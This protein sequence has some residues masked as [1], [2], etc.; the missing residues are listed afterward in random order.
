MQKVTFVRHGQASYGS[1]N[2]D[3]LSEVGHTQT[4]L[5][6]EHFKQ[7]GYQFDAIYTGKMVRH[8][9]TAD[10]ILRGMNMPVEYHQMSNF[11]EF[12]FE[13]VVAAY[14]SFSG[15][16]LPPKDA[17]RTDFYRIL[18]QAMLAWSNQQLANVPESWLAFQQRVVTGVEQ[19]VSDNPDARHIL[20]A[21]SGGA[22]AMLKGHVLEL[23]VEKLVDMNL[24]IRNASYHQYLV[25]S[26]QMLETSFNQIGH[27]ELQPNK[28]LL[29]YS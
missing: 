21:T 11:N 28:S 27:L 5:L 17:P 14:L 19:A 23:S 22:I 1:D 18:K 8:H 12:D 9:E 7:I 26:S 24:Q 16:T 10:Q 13:A 15:D 20:I 29:T 6:G 3:K 25:G 2:Y 4:R